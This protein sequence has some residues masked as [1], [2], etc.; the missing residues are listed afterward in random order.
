M[1][2]WLAYLEVLRRHARERRRA[3][4]AVELTLFEHHRRVQ[5]G[6]LYDPVR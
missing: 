1:A 4:A 6:R 2:D 5:R 3:G